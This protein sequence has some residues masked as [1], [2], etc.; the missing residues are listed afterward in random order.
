[1]KRVLAVAVLAACAAKPTPVPPPPSIPTAPPPDAAPAAA[2]TPEAR[3][4]LVVDDVFAGKVAELRPMLSPEVSAALSDDMIK[5]MPA[6]LEKEVGKLDHCDPPAKLPRKTEPPTVYAVPCHFAKGALL[7]WTVAFD[8][9]QRVAGLHLGQHQSTEPW[10][11]PPVA[12]WLAVQLAVAVPLPTDRIPLL[13]LF[14][15]RA[16]ASCILR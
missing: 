6:E 8:D 7:D 1:M 12:T 5:G 13:F 10:N 3:A 4:K 2:A 15:S 11:P 16:S 14:S 9:K